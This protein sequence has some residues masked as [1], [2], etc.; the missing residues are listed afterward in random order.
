MILLPQESL[1]KCRHLKYTISFLEGRRTH[2]SLH[3]V[4]KEKHY[5][6]NIFTFHDLYCK[7]NRHLKR[8]ELSHVCHRV[9]H[10]RQFFL[11]WFRWYNSLKAICIKMMFTRRRKIPYWHVLLLTGLYTSLFVVC[12]MHWPIQRQSH[13]EVSVSCGEVRDVRMMSPLWCSLTRLTPT[14]SNKGCRKYSPP[15]PHRQRKVAALT[16]P[17]VGNL[18]HNRLK[19]LEISIFHDLSSWFKSIFSNSN[20]ISSY[21]QTLVIHL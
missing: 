10:L 9:L 3:T 12:R 16:L 8:N 19:Q 13:F 15:R 20:L 7:Y 5:K 17:C 21:T 18:L 2:T 4:H 11:P 1:S 14:T 6:I